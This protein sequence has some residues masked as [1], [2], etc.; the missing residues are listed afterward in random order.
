MDLKIKLIISFI[1][2]SIV[3]I[4]VSIPLIMN[5]IPP[6]GLYGFRLRKTLSNKEIW[7]KANKF[8]GQCVFFA[9]VMTLTGCLWL[10]SHKESLSWY[11][12]ND[13]GFGFFIIP[14]TGALILS[15]TYIKKL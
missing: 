6:N 14:L 3:F 12:I 8:G 11:T 1:I 2:P 5:R 7:Y 10:W 9:G 15:L 13:V 4:C